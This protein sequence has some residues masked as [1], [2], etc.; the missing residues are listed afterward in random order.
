M[1]DERPIEIH[2]NRAMAA[3]M[4]LSALFI[5]VVAFSLGKLFPQAIT[6]GILLLVSIGFL[7]QPAIVVT[8]SEVQMRNMLGMTLKRH[9]FGSLAE[10]KMRDGALYSGERKIASR[11][12]LD[13]MEWRKLELAIEKAS[14]PEPPRPSAAP[15]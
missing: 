13:A 15:P 14:S 11:R 5:L 12:M 8:S 10:L 6:G 4:L 1:D 2:Y 3:V 9:P 7:T